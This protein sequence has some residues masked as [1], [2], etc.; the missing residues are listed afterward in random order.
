MSHTSSG[1]ID[2]CYSRYVTPSKSRKQNEVSANSLHKRT[3][4]PRPRQCPGVT[5]YT[6]DSD[7]TQLTTAGSSLFSRWT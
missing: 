3:E 1:Q 2:D 4:H 5:F 7:T 6:R